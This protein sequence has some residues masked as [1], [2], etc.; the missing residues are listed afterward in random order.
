MGWV[1]GMG[2]ALQAFTLDCDG[3]KYY[4]ACC[5]VST[6]FGAILTRLR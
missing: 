6:L 4:E 2:R 1:G 5:P 3:F